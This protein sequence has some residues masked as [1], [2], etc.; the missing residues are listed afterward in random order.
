[1]FLG[2][3]LGIYNSLEALKV[4]SLNSLH[5]K[6]LSTLGWIHLFSPLPVPHQN[7]GGHWIPGT[8][9]A[10]SAAVPGGFPVSCPSFVMGRMFCSVC[11]WLS[12]FCSW[13][14]FL[15]P[16]SILRADNSKPWLPKTLFLGQL[17]NF[18]NIFDSASCGTKPT[19]WYKH[20]PLL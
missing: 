20:L 12:L 11:R 1:M 19:S 5:M 9:V 6:L 13:P 10:W 14:W 3:Q 16:S 8:T 4:S 7:L 2:W 17:I 15:L 18:K